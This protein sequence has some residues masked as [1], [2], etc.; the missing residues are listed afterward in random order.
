[1]E[2]KRGQRKAA[3]HPW[4]EAAGVDFHHSPMQSMLAPGSTEVWLLRMEELPC[5]EQGPFPP[6]GKL[7][8]NNKGEKSP[9]A[10]FKSLVTEE[11][12]S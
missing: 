12:D 4:A 2:S 1:M 6:F 5:I 7:P 3:V 11:E 9:A 8:P 10:A